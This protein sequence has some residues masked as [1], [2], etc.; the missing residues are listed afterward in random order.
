[1]PR[2]VIG[3]MGPGEGAT[4]E[5]CQDAYALGHH[6][7]E[8]G[9]VVL[10]G[11][12]GV[13]VMDAAC[14]GAKA[15]GGLTVGVLPD[16]Q[17]Q[18][19]SDHVDIPIYTGLGQARNVVNILSSQVVIACGIGLGTASEVALALKMGKPTI[20]LKP[21]AATWHFFYSLE[22]KQAPLCRVEASAQVVERIRQLL[23][24]A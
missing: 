3:V 8:A 15:I 7:A 12:R 18:G 4:P 5:Q 10:T 23:A 14:R 1:M 21:D 13:G 19:T 17:N 2:V 11:G 16:M 6:L 24:I 22:G 20:L 9:W